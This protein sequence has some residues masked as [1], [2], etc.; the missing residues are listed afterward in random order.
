V[1][2]SDCWGTSMHFHIQDQLNEFKLLNDSVTANSMPSQRKRDRPAKEKALVSAAK[3]LFARKGYDVTTTREIAAAA[4]CAEGLIHRYFGGKAGLFLVLIRQRMEREVTDLSLVRPARNLRDE[5]IQLVGW[6][7]DWTW[8]DRE[9]LRVIVPRAVVD[10]DL[11]KVFGDIIA[12]G[13]LAAITSRLRRFPEAKLLSRA[14][15]E[16]LVVS[17]GAFSFMF[18]FLRP[19]VL[20]YD[21]AAERALAITLA[22]NLIDCNSSMSRASAQVSLPRI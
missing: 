10:G 9:F 14:Q 7:L 19:A 3:K 22:S 21:R 18:G 2:V 16:G 4:K 6:E 15:L 20:G 13:R 12:N 17:I 11:G 8:E 1:V 5:F